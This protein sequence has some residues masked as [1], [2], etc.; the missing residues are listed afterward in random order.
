MAAVDIHIDPREELK[1]IKAERAKRSFLTFVEM[2]R[3]E[4]DVQWFQAVVANELQIAG[5]ANEDTK[6]GLSMPPGCAKSEY[7]ILYCAWMIARD[8]DITIKY[9]TYNT[10]FAKKQFKRLKNIL[11]SDEYVELFGWVF[12]TRAAPKEIKLN[13]ENTAERIELIGGEGWV[14]ACGFNGGIT[15]GRCDVIVIDDPF[16]NHGEAYS[17]ATRNSRWNEYNASIKTRK[18]PK[19]PLR[20]LML[21]TRW[22][23]DD[24][25]G[26]CQ[27]LEA[28]EWRWVSFE[29]LKETRAANDDIELLD[30]REDGEVLWPGLYT[31]EFL[32]TQRDI[33]PM[34][35]MAMF[36]QRPIPEGGAL[37]KSA[38]FVNRYDYLPRGRG[39]YIQS[40][41][42]RGGGKGRKGNG[43]G[44]SWVVGLLLWKPDKEN[45]LYL[46]DVR[47][48]R[49]SPDETLVQFEAINRGT[50][51]IGDPRWPKAKKRYLELKADG[52]SVHAHFSR[53][54]SGMIGVEPDG[55]KQQRARDTAPFARAGQ[56]VLPERAL[57]LPLFESE[58]FSFPGG[59]NDDQ[60][61]AST[62]VLDQEFGVSA[63]VV[64]FE[65]TPQVRF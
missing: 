45:R 3:P 60:M 27:E 63:T 20:I 28:N 36:Q 48:E 57:W 23:L 13:K 54:F 19:R 56:L 26:R 51:E 6:L 12:N 24:L 31:K 7:A 18:R 17:L 41:D 21:F 50:D 16:K 38:W 44:T 29:A 22:H 39:H 64:E 1:R 59:V 40:W 43:E 5:T 4:Y 55:D 52:I 34:I 37:W 2:V 9:V 8:R 53:V 30:P 15:G 49:W 32:E 46:V 58:I 65:V 14:D 61:D 35:F 42:F 33:S 62:Q 10:T 47:R 11:A 25:A